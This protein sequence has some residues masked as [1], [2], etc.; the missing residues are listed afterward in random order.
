MYAI[1][2]N[3]KYLQ[4]GKNAVNSNAQLFL[5]TFQ[6]QTNENHQNSNN[7]NLLRLNTGIALLLLF[8]CV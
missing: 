4:I 2:N 5:T 6:M 1:I 8:H 7:L 3:W